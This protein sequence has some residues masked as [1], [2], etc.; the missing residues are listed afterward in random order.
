MTKDRMFVSIVVVLSI[1]A[2]IVTTVLVLTHEE[3]E[4]LV[5]D[6]PF[7]PLVGN[8]TAIYDFG[9]MNPTP[10]PTEL[11]AVLELNGTDHGVYRFQSDDDDSLVFDS[12]TDICSMEYADLADNQ[13]VNVGDVLRMTELYPDSQYVLRLIWAPTGDVIET[14]T[15]STLP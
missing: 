14:W 2:G 15:F 11:K 3:E 12:G 13:R 6:D 5:V 10:K 8:T 1:L 7:L 4:P 9:R